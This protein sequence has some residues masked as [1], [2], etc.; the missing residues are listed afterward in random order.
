MEEH[1]VK[2]DGDK[3]YVL[4]SEF[5]QDRE[6]IVC[7]PG[8]GESHVCFAEAFQKLKDFNVIVMDLPGF[9]N[10]KPSASGKH[11]T[12]RQATRALQVIDE[13]KIQRLI[14]IGHSWGGDVGTN[15]C[16]IDA[17]EG[18]IKKFINVEGDIHCG[19][20]IMSKRVCE[21]FKNS[22]LEDFENWLLKKDGFVEEFVMD[23][24]HAAGIRYLASVRIC[25]PKVYGET[26]C[27]INGL[28]SSKDENDIIEW[29]KTFASLR[30]PKI[31]CWGT[32]SIK[33]DS[34]K[35]FIKQLD[36]RSFIGANHWVMMDSGAEFYKF[37]S[38]YIND[39]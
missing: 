31:Y 20:V 16:A 38:Y 19:N 32:E 6:T 13:L 22:T 12:R 4:R 23:W 36:N 35:K 28:H 26:A 1:R 34:T 24:G 3:I 33:K 9:G 11:D 10:S 17:E 15:M 7:I 14:L 18:R 2:I 29:G 25:S 8:L 27:E 37:V 5:I 21:V 39:S 30:I